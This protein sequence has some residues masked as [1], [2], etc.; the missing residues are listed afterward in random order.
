MKHMCGMCCTARAVLRRPKT[1]ENLCKECFYHALE[2][3][4]HETV[5]KYELFKPGE[6]VALAASGG[7]DST[8]LVHI[9]TTLNERY[10]YVVACGGIFPVIK[11]QCLPSPSTYAGMDWTFC[12][13]RSMKVFRDTETTP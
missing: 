8:V 11:A 2:T 1:G 6:K 3:E 7:K 12:C 13:C 4:V 5:M 10:K 9:I